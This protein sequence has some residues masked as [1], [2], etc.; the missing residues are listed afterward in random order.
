MLPN[1][2][3]QVLLSLLVRV[4]SSLVSPVNDVETPSIFFLFLAMRKDRY[5]N[6]Y[7]SY[8]WFAD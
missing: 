7:C 5:T 2:C 8:A 6:G 3:K 1:R 4:A